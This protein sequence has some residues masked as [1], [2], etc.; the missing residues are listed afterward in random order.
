MDV[1]TFRTVVDAE[2]VIRLPAGVVLPK[3]SIEVTIKPLGDEA[4]VAG[5]AREAANARLRQHRVSL[6]YAT[7]IDNEAIDTDLSRVYGD[8]PKVP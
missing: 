3:G 8:R 6:G 1:V 5:S 4:V 2:Q 7:G